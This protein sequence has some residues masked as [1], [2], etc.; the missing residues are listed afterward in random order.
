V[1]ALE[2]INRLV[3]S[4]DKMIITGISSSTSS[5]SRSRD[6]GGGGGGGDWTR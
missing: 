5:S 4:L 2:C 6:G 3:S 1:N